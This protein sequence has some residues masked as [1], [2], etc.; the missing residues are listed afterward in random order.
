MSKPKMIA[1]GVG[2]LSVA[3]AVAAASFAFAG[4]DNIDPYDS[5]S[6]S[7]I[8]DNPVTSGRVE[9]NM[10]ATANMIRTI[11]P[12]G[13]MGQ[14]G[15]MAGM[16]VEDEFEYLTTMIPHHEEA[17]AA[18]T[19]L[20]DG[21]ESPE[22]RTFAEQIIETQKAEVRQ[23]AAWLAAWYPE[24]DTAVD[25][26]PMMRDLTGLRG[27]DL[28]QAF[29]EDMIPHHM[30]AVMMSQQVLSGDITI[31]DEVEPFAESIRDTQR[32]EIMQ[33]AG[34]LTEWFGA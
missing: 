13:V 18:A 29:L 28:D 30:A 24:R 17:V 8:A 23:M 11:G 32:A 4:D 22:M 10:G 9:N 7:R 19:V 16:N 25:Y 15:A 21:T 33:M 2:A 31:N 34:W 20:R 27:D 6:L 26:T 5:A 14:M 3:I 12:D 1:A